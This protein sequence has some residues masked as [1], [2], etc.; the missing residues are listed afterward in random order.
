MLHER[1]RKS[2]HLQHVLSSLALC[3]VT[4]RKLQHIVVQIK[5]CCKWC[6][7]TCAKR[8]R[9]DWRLIE[10]LLKI[11]WNGLNSVEKFSRSVIQV[12]VC[13]IYGP[14]L[15]SILIDVHNYHFT[16][17]VDWYGMGWDRLWVW[18]RHRSKDCSLGHRFS[19]PGISPFGSAGFYQWQ[20]E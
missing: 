12:P 9:T 19:F 8:K 15:V 2:S 3:V 10:N 6:G 13:G 20:K 18:C 7:Y 11:D 14:G 5:T 16:S 4:Q 17:G 1:T